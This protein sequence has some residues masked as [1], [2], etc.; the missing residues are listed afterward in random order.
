MNYQQDHILSKIDIHDFEI[1][2][3]DVFDTLI[4]RLCSQPEDIFTKVGEL[5][6][7][8][9][10]DYFSF[11]PIT[12]REI[13][14]CAEVEA[15]KFHANKKEIKYDNIFEFLP[16][17]K[18]IKDFLKKKE[19]EVELEYTCLNEFVYSFIKECH[20][21]GKK[22]ILISDMYLSEK[23]ISKLLGNLKVQLDII[24]KIYVSSDYNETKHEGGL[25]NIVLNDYSTVSP[26]KII[27]IGD[28]YYADFM[29]P[30]EYNLNSVY[31]PPIVE[32]TLSIYQ[33]EE[34][35][36]D[37]QAN[38]IRSIRKLVSNTSKYT[39]EKLTLYKIGSEVF[40]P[41]YSLFAEWVVNQAQLKNIKRIFP[42]MREG[43]LL[44][45]LIKNV[46]NYRNL[47]IIVEPIYISRK[48]TYLPTIDEFSI[49]NV[50]E[51]LSRDD[52]I[53]LDVFNLFL[54]PIENTEFETYKLTTLKQ[55]HSIQLYGQSLFAYLRNYLIQEKQIA[56]VKDN[57]V[58]QKDYIKQYIK[59]LSDGECFMTVDLGGNGTIQSNIDRLFPDKAVH[60][61]VYG[62]EKAL[63]KVI[64]GQKIISW[65]GFENEYPFLNELFMRHPELHE[66]II[67]IMEPGTSHYIKENQNKISPSFTENSYYKSDS[68]AI[69]Q[70]IIWEGIEDFQFY[71]HK[72]FRE[73]KNEH[74]IIP[75]TKGLVT[76]L[77][78]F[79]FYPTYSEALVLKD[80][81][82]EDHV[83]ETVSR[84][85][86]EDYEFKILDQN[87][88]EKFKLIQK[89]PKKED[90]VFWPEGLLSIRKPLFIFRE[91]LGK[92]NLDIMNDIANLIENNDL[93]KYKHIAIYGAGEIGKY[94]YK[95][96]EYLNIKIT[97][98]IDRNHKN[99][100]ADIPVIGMEN[101]PN[102]IDLI[103][104]ASLAFKDE[105]YEQLLE[106]YLTR[107][108]KPTIIKLR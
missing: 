95:I 12:Y 9:F 76:I 89:F 32:D 20:M 30:R 42:L 59:E 1:I 90:R 83:L 13:R 46:V 70:S 56:T 24:D 21:L 17:N 31:Y 29:K 45:R 54:L 91:L 82:F 74:K 101:T 80:F 48:A 33:L 105:I 49:Q 99:I 68:S 69:K 60:L 61:F 28:N 15:R 102:N 10:G 43:L 106:F 67:S 58:Q 93:N 65:L 8:E 104:I 3:I 64:K 2:S 66:A 78:R 41:F 87:S 16:F 35:I 92:Q 98:M 27:H 44:S 19:F 40:G 55:S 96:L 7:S 11:D 38:E 5:A 75:N 62:T 14:K 47:D 57:I 72:I 79:V 94:I 103:I 108:N 88:I 34:K 53:I 25:F 22:I 86:I 100:V 50:D 23:Q 51:V 39:G 18:E 71:L 36:S 107:N 77:K 73:K 63:N 37:S 97:L 6:K 52:L 26:D 4:F 81:Y 84:K 85:L